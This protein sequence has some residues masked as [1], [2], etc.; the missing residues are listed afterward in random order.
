MRLDE[1]NVQIA[2]L[3]TEDDGYGGGG[4]DNEGNDDIHK[5]KMVMVE[6]KNELLSDT[7]DRARS[8]A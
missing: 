5:W 3:M 4:S 6:R 1:L 7:A 8:L 2:K